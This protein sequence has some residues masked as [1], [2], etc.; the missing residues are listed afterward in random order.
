MENASIL[1]I[2]FSYTP[3]TCFF[4]LVLRTE[5]SIDEQMCVS[6][7]AYLLERCYII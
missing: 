2:L 5:A 1:L 4:L 6:L 3:N 7:A